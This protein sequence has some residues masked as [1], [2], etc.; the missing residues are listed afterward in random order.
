MAEKPRIQKDFVALLRPA[1]Q[2]YLIFFNAPQSDSLY[3]A[4]LRIG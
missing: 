4:L 2:G 3:I 1:A